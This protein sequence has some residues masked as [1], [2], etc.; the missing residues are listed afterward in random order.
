MVVTGV[1]PLK[2]ACE[3]GAKFVPV[4]ANRNGA[5]FSAATGGSMLVRVGVGLTTENWTEPERPPPGAGD[6]ACR[7]T[8]EKGS[9]ATA[10]SASS[11]ETSRVLPSTNR[12][13]RGRPLQKPMV[14]GKKFRPDI[15]TTTPVEPATT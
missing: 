4:S 1:N 11:S 9:V 3:V 12:V 15:V 14:L 7:E 6:P 10:T 5:L 13:A 2:I 8:T